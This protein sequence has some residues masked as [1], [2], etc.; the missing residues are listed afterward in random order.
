M[1][2]IDFI[3]FENLVPQEEVTVYVD[4]KNLWLA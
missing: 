1:E 4:E 3:C 2:D